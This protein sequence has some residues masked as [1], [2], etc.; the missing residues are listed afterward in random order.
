MQ[1]EWIDEISPKEGD[2]RFFIRLKCI[3][4]EYQFV[5]LYSHH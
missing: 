5:L 4:L 1:T 3:I 2:I